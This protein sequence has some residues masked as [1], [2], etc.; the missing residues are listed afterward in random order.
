MNGIQDLQKVLEGQARDIGDRT[1]VI[2]EYLKVATAAVESCVE[3]IIKASEKVDS[4]KWHKRLYHRKELKA[5]AVTC[6]TEVDRA[7]QLFQVCVM[8]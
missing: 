4:M 1:L 7:L 3:R 8:S 6:S 2:P 5:D